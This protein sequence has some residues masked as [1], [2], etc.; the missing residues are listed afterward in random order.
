MVERDDLRK[1]MEDIKRNVAKQNVP[2]P[3]QPKAQ[4]QPENQQQVSYYGPASQQQTEEKPKADEL[5][6]PEPPQ[7]Q[8][9]TTPEIE[10]GPLFIKQR[11]FYTAI[12]LLSAMEELV[13]NMQEQVYNLNETL[14][15]DIYFIEDLEHLLAEG[16]KRKSDIR[17]IISPQK[18]QY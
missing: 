12:N 17:E 15:K 3:P 11:K 13:G 10:Q 6:M 4:Q 9:V 18:E 14:R 2:Q 7:T 5:E 16:E 1:Q 8:E